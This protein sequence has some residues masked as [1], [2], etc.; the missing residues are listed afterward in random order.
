VPTCHLDHLAWQSA[1]SVIWAIQSRLADCHRRKRLRRRSQLV[2]TAK[3][4]ES[5]ASAVA[6]TVQAVT[7]SLTPVCVLGL[8]GNP[9]IDAAVGL[10]LNS[11]RS[12]I[13]EL[14]DDANS[15]HQFAAAGLTRGRRW[16]HHRVLISQSHRTH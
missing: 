11:R 10:R 4:A 12:N 14:L 13:C 1:D 8:N 2:R 16:I 15:S 6:Q 9:V 3:L 5:A 7:T